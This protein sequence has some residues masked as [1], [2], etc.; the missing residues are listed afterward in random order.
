MQRRRQEAIRYDVSKQAG[1]AKCR[2][3]ENGGNGKRT[4][5]ADE[6]KR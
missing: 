5:Y 2:P 4:K 1:Q 6:T 3:A